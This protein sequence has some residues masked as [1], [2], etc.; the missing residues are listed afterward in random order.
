[1]FITFYSYSLQ[2]C[3]ILIVVILPWLHLS[4]LYQLF[5]IHD[6]WS[7]PSCHIVNSLPDSDT[8]NSTG[9]EWT[10]WFCC[11]WN[12]FFWLS[13]LHFT[14][15]LVAQVQN[16]PVTFYF[17]LSFTFQVLKSFVFC[18]VALNFL[19][20][21]IPTVKPMAQIWV[22]AI[23]SPTGFLIPPSVPLVFVTSQHHNRHPKLQNQIQDVLSLILQK[24]IKILHLGTQ[25]LPG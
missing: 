22:F 3:K 24:C 17:F 12:E 20:L 8:R 13:C 15:L 1:M 14:N 19:Y 25:G 4:P 6:L 18:S 23:G 2:L 7:H 10:L 21:F 16:F 9:S 5:Q 11:H